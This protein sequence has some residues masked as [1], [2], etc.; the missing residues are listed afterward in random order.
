MKH[1]PI[2]AATQAIVKKPLQKRIAAG[3]EKIK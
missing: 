2:E 1:G 3:P